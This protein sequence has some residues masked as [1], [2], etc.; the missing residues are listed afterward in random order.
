M[1]QG[2]AGKDGWCAA[3]GRLTVPAA[4]GDSATAPWEGTAATFSE[5]GAGRGTTDTAG[6]CINAGSPAVANA[7]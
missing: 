7:E 3:T 2:T 5:A 4:E 1:G 6:R